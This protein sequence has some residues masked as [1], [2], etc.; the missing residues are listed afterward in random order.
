MN[1]V[2]A[3]KKALMRERLARKQAEKILEE[4]SRTLFQQNQTI[5]K[6]KEL[7]SRSERLASIG[8]LAAGIAHEINNPIGYSMSNVNMLREYL[9]DINQAFQSIQKNK[10]NQDT[11][12]E[13][14][15]IFKDSVDLIQETIE[16]LT[17]VKKIVKDVNS[18]AHTLNLEMEIVDINQCVRDA[19]KFTAN[20]CKGCCE[21]ML[22]LD[23]T[24][25]AIMALSDHITQVLVNLIKNAS[26]AVKEN[27]KV[28]ISTKHNHEYVLIKVQDNGV[29]IP[30]KNIQK[31]F[32]PFYTSKPIGVGT[33]LGL[34]ISYNIIEAHK[35][36]IQVDS[37]ENLGTIFRIYLPKE[38]KS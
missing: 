9:A 27:G 20:D 32:N 3:I 1:D 29:G 14:D 18:F 34:S 21:V 5:Q 30:K 11:Q 2:E 31:I 17:R 25:P 37:K 22:N 28:L 12:K 36:T 38:I 19:I 10:M 15:Y 8:Q 26:Q 35:G 7:L 6:Q 33:G 23:Q 4:K 24:L 13:L 16:G